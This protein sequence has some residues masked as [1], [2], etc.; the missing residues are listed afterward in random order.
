MGDFNV[1]WYFLYGSDHAVTRG[2]TIK[3]LISGCS[4]TL[5]DEKLQLGCLKIAQILLQPHNSHKTHLSLGSLWNPVI[6]LIP[7]YLPTLYKLSDCLLATPTNP[8]C[9]FA[10]SWRTRLVDFVVKMSRNSQG[11]L[12]H[13][14][15]KYLAPSK[16]NLNKSP[17]LREVSHPRGLCL[18]LFQKSPWWR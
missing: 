15:R 16:S 10:Y 9:T 18:S 1:E 17:R 3:K 4:S 7:D 11:N 5:S 2:N 12:L 14:L 6:N 8:N 13:C